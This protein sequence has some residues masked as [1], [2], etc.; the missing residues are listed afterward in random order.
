MMVCVIH[1]LV[2]DSVTYL[3]FDGAWFI[4]HRLSIAQAVFGL[5]TSGDVSRITR[6]A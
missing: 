5:S 1:V 6:M 4:E 2:R 3:Q